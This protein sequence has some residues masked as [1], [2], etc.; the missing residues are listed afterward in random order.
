MGRV[1]VD[2]YP[3]QQGPLEDVATFRTY[4]GGSPTNVAVAA[5]RHGRRS[6][7]ITAVGDDPFGRII[8]REFAKFGL[9]D[10]YLAV[11]TGRKTPL[12]FCEMF[13]PDHFPLYF[14]RDDAPDMTIEAAE[15]DLDQIRAADVFWATG[16]GLSAEPSRTATMAALAARGRRSF[17][18]LDLD[19]RPMLWPSPEAAHHHV[20][21]ALALVD[22]AVGNLDEFEIAVGTRDP[23]DAAQA[24][25][26]AGVSLAVVKKGPDGVLALDRH[27]FVDVPVIPVEVVNGL[28]AGDAFGG[29]LCHGLLAGWP[30]EET[31]QFANAAGAYVATQIACS[32]AMP[33]SEEVDAMRATGGRP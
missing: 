33:T 26:A 5:A 27:G 29:A 8:A 15:L 10:R 12:A 9:D 13:P 30:L 24:A 2:V 3:D 32:D 4:L 1:S 17:T 20:A 14:Y 18:I 23:K 28:G 7:V 21:A 22:V 11:R 19:H 16:T 31:L 6:A 25:L